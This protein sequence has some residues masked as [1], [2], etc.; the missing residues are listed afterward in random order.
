M[1][2]TTP[3]APPAFVDASEGTLG[4]LLSLDQMGGA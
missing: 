2:A 3:T 4:A 1:S